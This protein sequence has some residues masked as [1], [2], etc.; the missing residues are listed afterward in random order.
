M[1]EFGYHGLERAALGFVLEDE[2]WP[3]FLQWMRENHVSGAAHD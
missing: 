1:S 3:A 2:T